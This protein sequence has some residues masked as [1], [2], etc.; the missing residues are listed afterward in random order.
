MEI[1][2]KDK[3][4]RELCEKKAAAVKKLG[5]VSAR[6]LQ[7]RLADMAAASRVT[8]LV[9]GNPHPLKGDRQGQFALDLA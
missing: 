6:K 3:K 7:T 9:T 4:L 8:D 1:K 5:D 2:F